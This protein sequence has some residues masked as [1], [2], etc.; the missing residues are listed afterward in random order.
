MTHPRWR[1]FHYLKRHDDAIAV[2][3]DKKDVSRYLNFITHFAVKVLWLCIK[4]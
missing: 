1:T 3:N 4:M 2:A